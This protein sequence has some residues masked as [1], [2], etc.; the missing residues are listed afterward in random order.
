MSRI[1]STLAF[2]LAALPASATAPDDHVVVPGQR[3][4][5]VSI[6]MGPAELLQA[7]GAPEESRTFQDG[8]SSY[9]YNGRHL[10]VIANGGKV[11]TIAT[12]DAGDHLANGLKIGSAELELQAMMGS[13]AWKKARGGGDFIEYC[14]GGTSFYVSGFTGSH[15]PPGRVYEIKVDGCEP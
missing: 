5:P 13:P 2:V 9:D 10:Q 4:G 12:W 7:L 14:F 6:G 15:G 11:S 3:V 8:G 1:A